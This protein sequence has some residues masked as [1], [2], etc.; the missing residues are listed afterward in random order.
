VQDFL[1]QNRQVSSTSFLGW[2]N[3]LREFRK[4]QTHPKTTHRYWVIAQLIFS[5][6]SILCIAITTASLNFSRLALPHETADIVLLSVATCVVTYSIFWN[7]R[8]VRELTK[9]RHSYN[10]N[11]EVW[12][13]LLQVNQQNAQLQSTSK[14]ASTP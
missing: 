11:E 5:S 2:E 7:A 10:A 6:L 12:K 8:M 14:A 3:A 4:K 9:G 1:K 13:N